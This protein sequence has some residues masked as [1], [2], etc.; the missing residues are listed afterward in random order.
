M[1][2]VPPKSLFAKSMRSFYCA[3]LECHK[4]AINDDQ[5]QFFM[6]KFGSSANS[7]ADNENKKLKAYIF[8]VFLRLEY[9]DF[10]IEKS[11]K[12]CFF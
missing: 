11:C 9:I 8:F 2:T 12:M 7:L 1:I 10:S 5:T 6:R 4:S 3:Y